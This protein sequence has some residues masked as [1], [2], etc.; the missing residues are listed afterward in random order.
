MSASRACRSHLI[1]L[2]TPDLSFARFA[3]IRLIRLMP[4]IALAIAISAMYL[5]AKLASRHEAGLLESL[6]AAT[7]LGLLVLPFFHPP[8]AIGALARP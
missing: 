5:S 8:Q 4:L 2:V 6:A 1:A 7:A 3:R